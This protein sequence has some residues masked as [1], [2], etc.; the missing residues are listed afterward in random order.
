VRPLPI[1][2]FSV[3]TGFGAGLAPLRAALREGRSALAPD[4]FSRHGHSRGFIARLAAADAPG[5]V[6]PPA[7]ARFSCRA[8]AILY[9]AW[10]ADGFAAAVAR[11]RARWGA[12]RIAIV[13][14]TSTSGIAATEEA[15][16][17]RGEDG[18]LA[19]DFDFTHTQ[20]F[21]APARLLAAS[22]GI[23]GPAFVL[24]AAC[25]S[26]AQGFG[27]AAELI[28]AGVVDAAVVGGADSLCQMTLAG[29]AALGLIAPR[30]CRPFDRDREGI[31][32]GEGAG[33]FLLERDGAARFHLLGYG[34]SSD[35]HHMSAPHP[36]GEGA[37]RA[38]A[39]ALEAAGLGPEAIDYLN[40]HGTATPSNDAAEDRAV[41]A[42]FGSRLGR[43]Q[44]SATKGVT[45]HALG[46]AGAI[47]AAIALIALEDG[48]VPGTLFHETPDPALATPIV[49]AP[50]ARPLRHVMS[51]SF[52]FGGANC[53]L[54][55][56]RST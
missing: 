17:A 34:E 19:A 38:M 6:L 30:P 7:L 53:S 11:A 39:A 1:T 41:A 40:L 55:F 20:D 49:T 31:S 14:G 27:A 42:L 9:L 23:E 56:G 43:L 16:A 18:A 26:T 46:A 36:E 21:A 29:F 47:E 13:L 32:I 52:G 54:I 8:H 10:Q 45:G 12:G 3:A 35:G 2:A 28:E 48:L 15:Y 50:R 33:L 24:S 44:A 51:N 25:A 4:D 5:R 37:R 22:G